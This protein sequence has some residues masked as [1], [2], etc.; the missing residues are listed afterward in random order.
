MDGE[1]ALRNNDLAF[2]NLSRISSIAGPLELSNN[3][4]TG[5]DFGALTQVMD[6]INLKN[7]QLVSLDCNGVSASCICVDANVTLTKCPSKCTAC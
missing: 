7:N 2:L 6:L 5:V 3:L 4:L 1:V